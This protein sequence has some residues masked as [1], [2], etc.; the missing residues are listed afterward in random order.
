ML[1]RKNTLDG[2]SFGV[3]IAL[4]RRPASTCPPLNPMAYAKLPVPPIDGLF[5]DGSTRYLGSSRLSRTKSVTGSSD[6]QRFLHRI[7]LPFRVRWRF[8]EGR[9]CG[10]AR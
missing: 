7:S 8:G 6:T 2:A 3:S 4:P 5:F 1:K 9:D 10:L